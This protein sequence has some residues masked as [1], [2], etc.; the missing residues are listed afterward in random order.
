MHILELTDFSSVSAL[1][2]VIAEYMRSLPFDI[3]Y[4]SPEKELEDLSALYSNEA[5]GALFVALENET[6]AGCVAV[7]KLIHM[8]PQQ[9]VRTC[10][11]KRLYVLPAFRGKNIGHMLAQ[12]IIQKAKE[13][14]Y[15][16]MYLDTHRQAQA[17]AIAMY[18]RMGFEECADYHPN[19]GKLLCMRLN[20]R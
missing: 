9:N 15:H 6:I 12:A 8:H 14:G 18:K 10:E 20:L 17:Q 19:P 13:L 1:R 3:D 5:G 4:Q 16:E 7:K 11:M 2:E